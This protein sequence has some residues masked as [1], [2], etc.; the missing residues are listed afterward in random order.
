MISTGENKGYVHAL[1]T[2]GLVDGPGVRFVV[3]LSGCKMRCK[4]CHNPDTWNKK[5]E[6][7]EAEALYKH[8][9]R[10]KSYWKNNG[11]ITISGGEPLLQI[12]FVTAVFEAA[13]KE[14]IHTAVDTAGQPFCEDKEWLEKFEKLAAVTDLFILD[15]KMMDSDGHKELT[16]V[17][18]G[19]ILA[20]A[21]WLSDHGKKMWIRHVLVPGITDE[22]DDLKKMKEFIGSLKTVEKTEILPYHTLGTIK[23]KELGL[24]YPL[25]GVPVPTEK[26]IEK[27][28]LLLGLSFDKQ[29]RRVVSAVREQS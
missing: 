14:N 25:E 19:N 23:W 10:Y 1:E 8:M 9:R 6:L 17:D 20:M 3:F 7:W 24:S 16:G 29:I 4:F 11:G 15:L 27:A 21:K 12:D 26:Q 13:K 22:E 5:G 28:E 18:N 2:F